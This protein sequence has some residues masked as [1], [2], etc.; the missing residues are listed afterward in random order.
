MS[1]NLI[2]IYNEYEFNSIKDMNPE[3]YKIFLEELLLKA[4][5][6][7]KMKKY[8]FVAKNRLFEFFEYPPTLRDKNDKI[9][10]T[11]DENEFQRKQRLEL[12]KYY[13]KMCDSYLMEEIKNADDSK[14][15]YKLMMIKDENNK[16]I[17]AIEIKDLLKLL[18]INNNTFTKIQDIEGE[19]NLKVIKYN[20]KKYVSKQD[21]LN[22]LNN[23]HYESTKVDFA[24]MYKEVK[25]LKGC[26]D[27]E[28]VAKE[29]LKD[30]VNS[31]EYKQKW[32]EYYEEVPEDKRV[33]RIFNK[34]KVNGVEIFYKNKD[35]DDFDIYNP[36]IKKCDKLITEI[37][38]LYSINYW[39]TFLGIHIRS[40]NRYCELGTIKFYK[41]GAKYMISTE[42]FAEC[43]SNLKKGN[44]K[45][46]KKVGRK[47]KIDKIFID[48]DLLNEGFQNYID[49]DFKKLLYNRRNIEEELEKA[50]DKKDI[51]KMN[52]AL[53]QVN[54]DIKRVKKNAINKILI[55]KMDLIKDDVNE[56]NEELKIITT[57]KK[58][59]NKAQE[60]NNIDFA[61]Q[62][63]NI[64]EEKEKLLDKKKND[65]IQ[66]ILK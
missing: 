66:K 37:P 10:D 15:T 63:N 64:I 35:E 53:I 14:S 24:Q 17:Y 23:N 56:F 31:E 39:A 2:R 38:K 45:S 18:N 7:P 22:Y 55:D 21:I 33:Y 29:R 57:Y 44:R 5:N 25:K 3:N 11:Y 8:N 20:N 42:D 26:S 49:S 52:A 36:N 61:K 34:M 65:I 60:N 32:N 50:S 46:T 54:D 16:E 4:K 48:E 9:L 19:E 27:K 43:K 12:K 41:I 59:R 62:L 51:K 47:K 1:V 28:T 40:V 58:D 6:N 13:K 30:I